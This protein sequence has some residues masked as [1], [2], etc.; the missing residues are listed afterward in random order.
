M[1]AIGIPLLSLGSVCI[2]LVLAYVSYPPG[3]CIEIEIETSIAA[4]PHN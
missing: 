4:A 3:K 1:I 2:K